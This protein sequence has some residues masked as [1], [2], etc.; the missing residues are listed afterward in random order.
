MADLSPLHLYI[1]VSVVNGLSNASHISLSLMAGDDGDMLTTTVLNTVQTGSVPAETAGETG[2]S[3]TGASAG[4]SQGIQLHYVHTS[5]H[6]CIHAPL[7][8]CTRAP[9]HTCTHTSIH[10]FIHIYM[11]ACIRAGIHTHIHAYV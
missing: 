4:D 6:P 5:M 11:H 8:P 7:H 1:Y 10:T 9:V 2:T 3:N